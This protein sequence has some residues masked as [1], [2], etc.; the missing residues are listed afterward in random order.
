MSLES[1]QGPQTI[2]TLEE[3]AAIDQ[4]AAALKRVA[5]PYDPNSGEGLYITTLGHTLEDLKRYFGGEPPAEPA[6]AQIYD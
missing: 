6:P 1:H 2:F 4:E 3:L 5:A